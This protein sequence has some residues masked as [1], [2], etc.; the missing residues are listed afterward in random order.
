M[1][2]NERDVF[3]KFFVQDCLSNHLMKVRRGN[4]DSSSMWSE[5]TQSC[6]TVSPWTLAHQDFSIHGVFQARILEWAAIS[7]SKGTSPPRDQ[8]QLSCTEGRRFTL[9]ATR[10]VP[11]V[12]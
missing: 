3:V 6:L 7:F 5:V 11:V 12:V 4:S 1:D 2:E 10:E 9:W 8:T